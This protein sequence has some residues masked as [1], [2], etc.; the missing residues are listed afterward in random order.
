MA[1]PSEKT[2]IKKRWW[3]NLAL[4]AIVLGLAALVVY[5][6]AQEKSEEAPSL[7]ALHSENISRIRLTRPQQPG[8][9]L[10]KNT[11]GWRLTAP[12]SARVNQ[13]NVDRLLRVTRAKS[14]ARVQTGVDL[15]QY[16]LD[17]PQ[18]HLWFNDEEIAF[19]APHPINNQI[20]VRYRDQIHLIPSHHY[21][22]VSYRYDHYID[23]RLLEEGRQPI[24]FRLPDFRLTLKDGVW[25]RLPENRK[26]A[27]DNIN[28]FVDEWRHAHALTVDRYTGKH[29][30]EWL[31]IDFRGQNKPET[32][33]LGILAY[34]PNFILYRKDEGLEYHFPEDT[35]KRLMKI[36]EE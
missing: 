24:G 27:T 8:T 33:M 31:K 22:P 34:K 3:L 7:T 15:G 2:P 19:G 29:A 25:R 18:A 4:I 14:E 26:L 11:A 32:L 12:L 36:S 17:K 20:Y 16:G 30:Q 35:G 28:R 6:R 10:E 1:N 23:T 9:V 5:K 21:A 13:F